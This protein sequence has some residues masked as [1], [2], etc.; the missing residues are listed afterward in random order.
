MGMADTFEFEK[1]YTNLSMLIEDGSGGFRK[2]PLDYSDLLTTHVNGTLPKRLLVEG[3]GGAGKTTFCSKIAWD[4]TNGGRFQEFTMV[5]V[6]H[7][8]DTEDNETVGEIVKRLSP[9]G[10]PSTSQADR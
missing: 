10:E 2:M 1:I 9:Q 3:E 6:I 5:L 7:L 8:R 4:W